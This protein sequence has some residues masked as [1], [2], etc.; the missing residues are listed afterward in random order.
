ML[1]QY[2]ARVKC[3]K[4]GYCKNIFLLRREAIENVACPRCQ[5]RRLE[6]IE[7]PIVEPMDY[8]NRTGR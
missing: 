7:V 6:I 1:I 3:A 4:C 8:F 2:E 5:E